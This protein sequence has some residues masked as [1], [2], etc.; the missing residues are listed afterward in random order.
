MP[1]VRC[2]RSPPGEPGSGIGALVSRSSRQLLRGH[3]A[4]RD[5]VGKPFDPQSRA[6]PC[7]IRQ[8]A[9]TGT[10]RAIR[11]VRR[12]QQ[13]TWIRAHDGSRALGLD[14]VWLLSVIRFKLRV[15]TDRR[16]GAT[17][18]VASRQVNSRRFAIS[19]ARV[20]LW[21]LLVARAGLAIRAGCWSWLRRLSGDL[22]A[23]A[24]P[25]RDAA[26]VRAD[27]GDDAKSNV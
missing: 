10:D 9:V 25:E 8:L 6:R 20:A 22:F 13:S 18:S 16:I 23:Q 1:S 7:S 24:V 26:E 2:R 15:L 3:H 27:A 11:R 5:R 12:D 4:R 21:W 14:Q 17:N 19:G